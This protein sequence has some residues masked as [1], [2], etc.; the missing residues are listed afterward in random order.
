MGQLSKTRCH[1]KPLYL[2]VRTWNIRAVKC[3]EKAGFQIEGEPFEL[4]TGIGTGMFYRMTK[5]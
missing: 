2:E 5:R 1:D 4:T 3:Y